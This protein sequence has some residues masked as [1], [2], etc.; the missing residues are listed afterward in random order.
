MIQKNLILTYPADQLDKPV[1][2]AVIR[3]Y[4]VEVNILQARITPR[5]EG[6]MFAQFAGEEAAVDQAIDYLQQNGVKVV[7]PAKNLVWDEDLCVHCGACIG[8]CMARAL[9][10][11]PESMKTVYDGA[12]CVA[13]DL[14]IPACGYGAIES[15]GEHLKKKGEL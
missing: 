15:I 9:V 10:Q 2:S 13:C 1:I 11:D 14:C 8:Q 5:E 7:L 3:T 4:D 6:R 12:L